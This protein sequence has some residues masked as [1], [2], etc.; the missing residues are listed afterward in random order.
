MNSPNLTNILGTIIHL[1]VYDMLWNHLNHI[2]LGGNAHNYT[3]PHICWC[4]KISIWKN[5]AYFLVSC[6]RLTDGFRLET[7]HSRIVVETMVKNKNKKGFNQREELRGVH[8]RSWIKTPTIYSKVLS[9]WLDIIKGRTWDLRFSRLS[10][11][12]LIIQYT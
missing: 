6:Y 3:Q 9:F 4:K 5:I 11:H 8:V 10:Q 7:L 1:P 12:L 2:I